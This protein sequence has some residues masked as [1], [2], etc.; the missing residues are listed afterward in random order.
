MASTKIKELLSLVNGKRN[1]FKPV[2]YT[3]LNHMLGK[4]MLPLKVESHC[5]QNLQTVGLMQ[6]PLYWAL[7]I[8][9]WQLEI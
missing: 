1:S 9:H 3:V 6:H 8:V 4:P 7:L 2:Y 5:Q